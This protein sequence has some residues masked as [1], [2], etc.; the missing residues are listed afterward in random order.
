MELIALFDFDGTLIKKDSMVL[1]FLRY[2]DLSIR[3][4]PKLTRLIYE[5][6]KYFLKIY[7]QKQFKEIYINLIINSSRYKDRKALFDDF[8]KYLIGMIFKSAKKKISE[9]KSKGYTVILLSAS[10]DLYL[11]KIS[12]ELGF[13]ELICTRMDYEDNKAVVS[14]LNCYGKNKI[15]MLLS[16]H[17]GDKVDWKRS[18]C[19][20]DSESDRKLLSLFGNPYVVNNARFRKK[21]PEFKSVMWK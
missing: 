3:N 9:L 18:Y 7:S 19:Y 17:E 15:K 16:S 12:R 8:S 21:A 20:S 1:L 5:T 14:G 11:K 10:P 13:S 4:V 2:F 6:I